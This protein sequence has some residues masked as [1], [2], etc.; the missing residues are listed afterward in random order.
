MTLKVKIGNYPKIILRIIIQGH[1]G[2]LLAGNLRITF[3][4][5]AM[6]ANPNL[7]RLYLFHIFDMKS[8]SSRVDLSTHTM[9]EYLLVKI[10]LV[11]IM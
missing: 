8:P 4:F 9:F 10:C 3:Q 2:K 6:T 5:F 1:P 11:Y 7:Y